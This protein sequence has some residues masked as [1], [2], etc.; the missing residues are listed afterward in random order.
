MDYMPYE[1][2]K[3]SNSTT[4][5]IG[6]GGGEDILVALAAGSKVTAVELNPLIISAVNQFGGNSAGNL[7]NRKDVQLHTDDGRRF[8]GS[9]NST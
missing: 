4:L 6:S 8:I 2:S 1:V 5:V 9:T 3:I 7:Y